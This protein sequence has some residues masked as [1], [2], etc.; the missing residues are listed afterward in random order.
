VPLHLLIDR[1]LEDITKGDKE[2][3]TGGWE[4][5]DP[6][7]ST[8]AASLFGQSRFYAALL[9]KVDIFMEGADETI[10]AVQSLDPVVQL[11][12]EEQIWKRGKE[13]QEQLN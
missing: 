3:T 13:L 1:L 2:G 11:Q 4:E 7:F 9:D 12:V 6:L 5:E 10:E 8:T